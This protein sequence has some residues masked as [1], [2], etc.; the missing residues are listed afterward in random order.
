MERTL[1]ALLA[2]LVDRER[3][4]EESYRR[5][6]HEQRTDELAYFFC[7]HTNTLLHLIRFKEGNLKILNKIHYKL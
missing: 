7:C 6:Q 5:L 2:A 4:S 1:F 3:E